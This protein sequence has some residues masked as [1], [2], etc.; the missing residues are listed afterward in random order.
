VVA[1]EVRNLAQRTAE[2]IIEINQ[3]IQ[4]VQTGAVDAAQAI[5][6]GQARSDESVEQVTRPVRC[7]SAS[8]M[9]WKRS[10]T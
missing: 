1:D 4:N 9:R 2:S 7:W 5:E 6:S 8:P 3:I 10:A